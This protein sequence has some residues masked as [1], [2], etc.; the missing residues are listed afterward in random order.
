[1]PEMIPPSAAVSQA[2]QLFFEQGASPNGLVH[3]AVWRSW[4]RCTEHGRKAGETVI[5]NSLKRNET[6][7]LLERNR[8]LIKASETVMLRLAKAMRGTG[9]N[10]IL[11]NHA[12][13]CIANGPSEDCG[14]LIRQAFRPGVDLSEHAIGTNAMTASMAEGRPIGIFGREHFFSQNQNFQCV[15]APIFDPKGTLLGSIDI[16]RDSPLPHRQFGAMSLM[17]DCAAAIET[18]LFLQM[19]AHL[20]V[21][22]GWRAETFGRFSAAILAFGKDGE[23]LAISRA[24]R[25]LLGIGADQGSFRYQ[26]L[27]HGNY[28][29]FFDAIKTSDQPAQLTLQS[30]L[31]LFAQPLFFK[32]AAAT[33]TLSRPAGV[34]IRQLVMPEFGDAEVQISLQRSARA[35]GAGLPILIH[36]ETGTG[37]EVA[38]HA[39]H[40]NS[41]AVDGPFVAINCGAIP[42]DLIEG[43]LFGYADGAY[44]GAR[45]GGAKGKI[46]EANGGTLFL[47]EIGDMPL[48]LQTRLLRV[49]ESREVTRLGESTARKLN[50]QVISA[51]HQDLDTLVREQRFRADLYYRLNG[52]LLS[53]PPLRTRN[54]L[55][56][57]I[58]AL[59]S[60]EGIDAARLTP[61]SAAALETYRWPGNTREL[62]T[63]LRFAKAMAEDREP[64]LLAHFPDAL[65][66]SG[67]MPLTSPRLPSAAVPGASKQLK[68]LESEV[69]NNALHEA[70]GNISGAARQLGISR[71]T[72]HRWLN[73][74]G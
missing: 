28:A 73:K 34:P 62:R 10:I 19:P 6:A 72:L 37:K 31:P 27:F 41:A 4:Q 7:T 23:V 39:L 40:T 26:D 8:Q 3:D 15:A 5:F 50:I 44:T 35:L 53:L 46:E 60:E 38:A 9:Y 2:R 65:H 68:E 16:S 43:E 51:T 18:S 21:S 30:G 42:R 17:L 61:E 14:D 67:S 32:Q 47:D 63:T 74:N 20:S 58:A 29:G 25:R 56:A 36:G 11:T 13:V 57:L 64:I 52:I 33:A 49:L 59:L 24:A 45:R 70:K 55:S 1:M 54:N 66:G 71:S 69:I 22:L 48:D 12:G